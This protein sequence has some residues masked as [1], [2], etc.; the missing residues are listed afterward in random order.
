MDFLSYLQDGDRS[1]TSRSLLFARYLPDEGVE[2]GKASKLEIIQ[3]AILEGCQPRERPRQQTQ[4]WM[5]KAV[6]K[7]S[8]KVDGLDF[9]LSTKTQKAGKS[10]ITILII[11]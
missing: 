4:Q 11:F 5:A 9:W 10:I 8:E 2:R 7:S 1:G 6:E 3:G